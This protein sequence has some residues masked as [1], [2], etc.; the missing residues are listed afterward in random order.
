[1]EETNES[2]TLLNHTIRWGLILGVIAV[3]INVLLYVIDESMMVQL[4]TLFISLLVY[5][6]IA[7]YAGIDYRKM[8]GG[9][10]TY[11]KAFQHGFLVLAISALVGT[12]YNLLLHFVIDTD[13]AERLTEASIE[14]T[15][16]MME[17]FGAPEDQIEKGLNDARERTAKQFTLSGMAL[18]YVF[19]LGFSAVMAL[20][21]ALFVR[22]NEPME[23]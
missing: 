9:Y 8:V 5:M 23:M 3:V 17:G 15:R 4:K 22:R 6:G 16:Q 14:N 1:M 19:I 12:L 7:I 13:L 21:S 2:P 20:I 11:G 18:G 10:L